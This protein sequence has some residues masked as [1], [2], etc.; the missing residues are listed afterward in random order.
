MKIA[1]V[2]TGR[3]RCTL[4]AYYLHSQYD[5]LEFVREFYT[6][7]NW[8][9]K[10][11]NIE[12]TEELLAKENYIVKIMSLNLCDCGSYEIKDFKFEEYDQLHLI[13]RHDFFQQCCSWHVARTNDYYHQ[14]ADLE[15]HGEDTFNILR[16]QQSKIPL[17]RIK[18]YAK[19]VETYLRFKE[20]I[21]DKNLDYKL[22]TY[23]DVKQ[24]DKKQTVLQDSKLDYSTMIKNYHLKDAVNEVFNKHFSY[25]NVTYDLEGFNA[26]ISDLKGLRSLQSF[27][28]KMR[29]SWSK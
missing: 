5:D 20:Y 17:D 23:E 21:I 12:L 10:H 11:N 1:V 4:L 15:A 19:Y 29:Q 18:E 25:E 16:K 6:E 2:S 3:S 9:G 8:K 28:N 24:Y 7:A 14:R 26:E 27:A 13:E 22:Y